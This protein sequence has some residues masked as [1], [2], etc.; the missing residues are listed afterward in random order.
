MKKEEIKNKNIEDLEEGNMNIITKIIV[1]IREYFK[2][3]YSDHVFRKVVSIL[4]VLCFVLNIANLPAYAKSDRRAKDNKEKNEQVMETGKTDTSEVGLVSAEQAMKAGSGEGV[5]TMNAIGNL[6]E[7]QVDSIIEIDEENGIVKDKTKNKVVAV[8]NAETEQVLGYPGQT[9][10]VYYQALV[11]RKKA[12]EKGLVSTA[13]KTGEIEKIGEEAREEIKAEKSAEEIAE[14]KGTVIG[15]YKAEVTKEDEEQEE[16]AIKGIEEENKEN[17]ESSKEYSDVV[18]ELA[19]QSGVS[20]EEVKEGLEEALA[21]KSEEEKEGIIGLLAKFFEQ[22]GDIINCAVNALGEMLNIASKGVLGLQALLVEISTGLF[23]KGN[24]DL[25]N[26]GESQLMTS[27]ETMRAILAEY[28]KEAI[29]V[30]S[31]IEVFMEGLKAGESAVVW[32]NGDHYITVSKLESGNFT[33]VDPNVNNGEAVEY[34]AQGLKDVLT[35]K[36]G[37]DVNG[38]EVGISYQAEGEDGLIRVLSDSEG[39]KEQVKEG[40]VKELSKEEMIEIEGARTI[41]HVEKHIERTVEHHKEKHVEHHSETHTETYTDEQG[42][43]QTNTWTEEWD[44]IW[45]E[46]WDEVK[47]EEVTEEWDEE[48]PDEDAEKLD[49]DEN[50]TLNTQGKD[51]NIEINIEEEIREKDVVDGVVQ[52]EQE[53]ER[54]EIS[55]EVWVDGELQEEGWKRTAG[56]GREITN[57]EEVS[58]TKKNLTVSERTVENNKVTVDSVVVNGKELDKK[59]LKKVNDALAAGGIGT[60]KVADIVQGATQSV[61]I[62]ILKNA[63]NESQ[64]L[65]DAAGAVLSVGEVEVNGVTINRSEGTMSFTDGNGNKVT[66]EFNSMSDKQYEQ[67]LSHVANNGGQAGLNYMKTQRNADKETVFKSAIGKDDQGRTYQEEAAPRSGGNSSVGATI[68][69]YYT[70][71]TMTNVDH[72][73]LQLETYNNDMNVTQQQRFNITEEAGVDNTVMG[74]NDGSYVYVP[75]G[76]VD[77]SRASITTTQYNKDGTKT[78]YDMSIDDDGTMHLTK[79]DYD[80]DGGKNITKIDATEDQLMDKQKKSGSGSGGKGGSDVLGEFAQQFNQVKNGSQGVANLAVDKEDGQRENIKRSDSIYKGYDNIKKIDLSKASVYTETADG[81]KSYQYSK[82]DVRITINDPGSLSLGKD[83]QVNVS[84]GAKGIAEQKIDGVTYRAG[85]T[86]NGDNLQVME[87]TQQ[88]TKTVDGVTVTTKVGIEFDGKNFSGADFASKPEQNV[89]TLKDGTQITGVTIDKDKN[90]KETLKYNTGAKVE[91]YDNDG[92]KYSA[93]LEGEGKVSD[94]KKGVDENSVRKSKEF[95]IELENGEK[96]TVEVY[97]SNGVTFKNGKFSGGDFS[98]KEQNYIKN[99]LPDGTVEYITGI[100][101]EEGENG[102]VGKVVD[103]SE[104]EVKTYDETYIYGKIAEQTGKTEDEVRAEFEAWGA[105]DSETFAESM[106]VLQS[107]LENGGQVVNCATEAIGNVLGDSVDLGWTAIQTLAIDIAAGAFLSNNNEDSDMINTSMYAVKTVLNINSGTGEG[108]EGVIG[109]EDNYKGFSFDNV[110]SLFS[111][112][113][114]GE[115]V[116][117]NIEIEGD[118]GEKIGHYITVTKL[119]NGNYSVE[120]PNIRKGNAVEYTEEGLRNVFNGQEGID[121]KGNET[122]AKYFTNGNG[123]INVVSANLPLSG[124]NKLEDGEMQQIGGAGLLGNILGGI[125]KIFTAATT[126]RTTSRPSYSRPRTTYRPTVRSTP[127]YATR[128]VQ[129]AASVVKP[130]ATRQ[131]SGGGVTRHTDTG[132]GGIGGVLGGLLNL[133]GGR[134]NNTGGSNNSGSSVP[135]ARNN[136]G[137]SF[138]DNIVNKFNSFRDRYTVSHAASNIDGARVTRNGDEW[139]LSIGNQSYSASEIRSSKDFIGGYNTTAAVANSQTGIPGATQSYDRENHEWTVTMPESAGGE[140]YTAEEIGNAKDF[141]NGYKSSSAVTDQETGIPGA[142]RSYDRKNHEWTVTMPE[143]AGG[144]TYTMSEVGDVTDFIN[145]Y[146]SSSAITDQETGIPGATRSFD[147][148][149]HEWVVTMPESAGGESYTMSEIDDAT[150]FINGYNTTSSVVD[151]ETG[152]PGATRSFDRDTHEWVV[153]M[154]ESAG[155]ETY[156]IEEMGDIT[157][158]INGYKTAAAVANSETGIPG[159]TQSYDKEKHE[160]TVIIPSDVAGADPIVVTASDIEKTG[161]KGV[162]DFI[163]QYNKGGDIIK[164]VDEEDGIPDASRVYDSETNTWNIVIPGVRVGDDAIIVPISAIDNVKNFNKQYNKGREIALSTGDQESGVP[165]MGLTYDSERGWLLTYTNNV[166]TDPMYIDVSSIED[167]DSFVADYNTIA[168]AAAQVNDLGENKDDVVI[169]YGDDGWKLTLLGDISVSAEDI[170]NDMDGFI[171]G[172]KTARDV[173]YGLDGYNDESVKVSYDG[174]NG[175][176]VT[177]GGIEIKTDD[178]G[179]GDDAVNKFIQEYKKASDI[180]NSEAGDD[181]AVTY[182]AENNK[183]QI[184]YN[185]GEDKTIRIEDI[186]LSAKDFVAQYQT[187]KTVGIGIDGATYEYDPEKGWKLTVPDIDGE[188][189]AKDI[190]SGDDFV[191]Q[192]KAM[193]SATEGLGENADVAFSFDPAKG[194][195]VTVEGTV[196]NGVDILELGITFGKDEEENLTINLQGYDQ[197][198]NTSDIPDIDEFISDYRDGLEIAQ[199]PGLGLTYDNE[200]HEWILSYNDGEKDQQIKV[201]EIKDKNDFIEQ[202]SKAYTVMTGIDGAKYSYDPEKGWSVTVPEVEDAI[203]ANDIDDA[204]KFVSGY[205]MAKA[206]YEYGNA[207]EENKPAYTYNREDGSWDVT[208]KDISNNITVFNMNGDDITVKSITDENGTEKAEWYIAKVNEAFSI[209]KEEVGDMFS[210]DPTKRIQQIAVSAAQELLTTYGGVVTAVYK[211]FAY[212]L[213][214]IDKEKGGV[215]INEKDGTMTQYGADGSAV[216]INLNYGN[217][218]AEFNYDELRDIAATE[219]FDRALDY[220]KCYG[221]VETITAYDQYGRELYTATNVGYNEGDHCMALEYNFSKFYKGGN[222]VYFQNAEPGSSKLVIENFYPQDPKD[223]SIRASKES[224]MVYDIEPFEEITPGFAGRPMS[225][226]TINGMQIHCGT[227]RSLDNVIEWS[228][229]RDPDT[230]KITQTAKGIDFKN[231]N[232]VPNGQKGDASGFVT[233]TVDGDGTILNINRTDLAYYDSEQTGGSGQGSGGGI[234]GEYQEIL[235]H[236]ERLKA[237]GDFYSGY[238]KI[239]DAWIDLSQVTVRNYDAQNEQFSQ[240]GV[241]LDNKDLVTLVADVSNGGLNDNWMYDIKGAVNPGTGITIFGTGPDGGNYSVEGTTSSVGGEGYDWTDLHSA[242]IGDDVICRINV[243]D[244]EIMTQK[245]CTFSVEN[246][247]GGADYSNPAENFRMLPNHCFVYG[248]ET[249]GF[250]ASYKDA[251]LV[252]QG[253]DTNGKPTTYSVDLSIPNGTAVQADDKFAQ[254]VNSDDILAIRSMKHDVDVYT[255]NGDM[256]YDDDKGFSGADFGSAEDNFIVLPNHAMV[257]GIAVN[258]D[259]DEASYQDSQIV[260]QGFDSEGYDTQYFASLNSGEFY[261]GRT[262]K[263]TDKYEGFVTDAAAMRNINGVEIYT[264]NGITYTDK[265]GF[266]GA[267]YGDPAKNFRLLEN[268]AMVTGIKVDGDTAT[269]ENSQIVQ[270]R[271]D[272]TTYFAY[273]D[274]TFDNGREVKASDK[275]ENHLVDMT[276]KKTFANGEGEDIDVYTRNGITYTDA[277]GFGGAN[278]G[279]PAKNF[280]NFSRGGSNIMVSGIS[281]EGGTV[282]Y[283]DSQMMGSD[284]S[285]N[286]YNV[287]LDSS[288]NGQTV[289]ENF[290][291][292]GYIDATQINGSEDG[293]F[294]RQTGS[295]DDVNGFSGARFVDGNGV[296]YSDFFAQTGNGDF[297]CNI[298]RLGKDNYVAQEN[299]DDPSKSTYL[300]SSQYNAQYSQNQRVAIGISAG[301]RIDKD[302]LDEGYKNLDRAN[303]VRIW[304]TEAQAQEMKDSVHVDT[305]KKSTWHVVYTTNETITTTTW[306]E[307]DY[308]KGEFIDCSSTTTASEDSWLIVT[309]N[310]KVTTTNTIGDK[311]YTTTQNLDWNWGWNGVADTLYDFNE[312]GKFDIDNK[313]LPALGITIDRVSD[314]S[315]INNLVVRRTFSDGDKVHVLQETYRYDGEDK[316]FEGVTNYK[317]N[318]TQVA[319]KTAS[320]SEIEDPIA[321]DFDNNGFLYTATG[322]STEVTLDDN[323]KATGVAMCSENAAIIDGEYA[324]SVVTDGAYKIFGDTPEEDQILNCSNAVIATHNYETKVGEYISGLTDDQLEATKF[325]LMGSDGKNHTFRPYYEDGHLIYNL[326]GYENKNV[327]YYDSS[328]NPNSSLSDEIKKYE[329]QGYTVEVVS[330]TSDEYG[331]SYVLNLK[332]NDVTQMEDL[333]FNK[334]FDGN[335]IEGG[336]DFGI[337]GITFDPTSGFNVSASLILKEK[338][339][340]RVTGRTDVQTGEGGETPESVDETRYKVSAHINGDQLDL[341]ATDGDEARVSITFGLGNLQKD[342]VGSYSFDHFYAGTELTFFKP[343]NLESV[344]NNARDLSNSSVDLGKYTQTINTTVSGGTIFLDTDTKLSDLAGKVA[345]KGVNGGTVHVENTITVEGENGTECVQIKADLADGQNWENAQKT[346]LHGTDLENLEVAKPGDTILG[347]EYKGNGKIDMGGFL[348][349]NG[350]ID[351]NKSVTDVSIEKHG[352]A[353]ACEVVAGVVVSIVGIVEAIFVA[354]ETLAISLATGTSFTDNWNEHFENADVSALK[355]AAALIKDKQYSDV[356]G[357]E[358]ASAIFSGVAAVAA[359]VVAVLGIIASPFTAGASAVGGV[360]FAG[361]VIGAVIGTTVAAVGA[362]KAAF[363]ASE[364]LQMYLKTGD[365]KYMDAFWLNLGLAIFSIATAGMAADFGNIG[366]GLA[367]KLVGKEALYMAAVAA[368]KSGG[369][370]AAEQ[371]VKSYGEA[372]TKAM[373]RHATKAAARRSASLAAKYTAQSLGADVSNIVIKQAANFSLKGAMNTLKTAPGTVLKEGLKNPWVFRGALMTTSSVMDGGISLIEKLTGRNLDGTFLGGLHDLSRVFSAQ[374]MLGFSQ[375]SEDSWLNN[376]VFG[377]EGLKWSSVLWVGGYVFGPG[378]ANGVAGFVSGVR[379]GMAE[380][381][382]FASAFGSQISS[383]FS[384]FRGNISQFGTYTHQGFNETLANVGKLFG[385]SGGGLTGAI[386]AWGSL[387]TNMYRMV[388]LNIGMGLTGSGFRTLGLVGNENSAFGKSSLGSLLNFVLGEMGVSQTGRALTID[389][390]FKNSFANESLANSAMFGVIMYALMPTVSGMAKGIKGVEAIEE[391]AA[392]NGSA[393][394]K[395]FDGTKEFVNSIW[396]EGFNEGIVQGLV[397][398]F[399]GPQA[400]EYISEFAF[401]DTSG[402]M[403]FMQTVQTA[404]GNSYYGAQSAARS[405]TQLYASK[406]YTDITFEAVRNVNGGYSIVMSGLQGV[407]NSILKGKGFAGVSAVY[408]NGSLSFEM[409]NNFSGNRA[410]TLAKA[411]AA[412]ASALNIDLNSLSR[413]SENSDVVEI[414]ERLLGDV[415]TPGSVANRYKVSEVGSYSSKSGLQS[416]MMGAYNAMNMPGFSGNIGSV[417]ATSTDFSK[418]SKVTDITNAIEQGKIAAEGITPSEIS[419]P[420]FIDIF[421]RGDTRTSADLLGVEINAARVRQLYGNTEGNFDVGKF[422]QEVKGKEISEQLE[423][424][425]SVVTLTQAGVNMEDF[426][427]DG[428]LGEILS[429]IIQ[430]DSKNNGA[431]AR[432]QIAQWGAMLA[433]NGLVSGKVLIGIAE[434]CLTVNENG[435]NRSATLSDFN[436]T[437]L[438]QARTV[439]AFLSLMQQAIVKGKGNISGAINDIVEEVINE[440]KKA[441]DIEIELQGQ[442]ELTDQ[443]KIILREME[444]NSSDGII[445]DY[446]G[447]RLQGINQDIITTNKDKFKVVDK[448]SNSGYEMVNKKGNYEI[449]VDGESYG[450]F[451]I[452]ALFEMGVLSEFNSTDADALR[453]VSQ[454][455]IDNSRGLEYEILDSNGEKR[456]ISV[457][458][459]DSV[460]MYRGLVNRFAQMAKGQIKE[461]NNQ[462]SEEKINELA[463]EL[464]KKQVEQILQSEDLREL[465]GNINRGDSSQ[466]SD[467]TTINGITLDKIAD[468][469]GFGGDNVGLVMRLYALSQYSSTGE[470]EHA[471]DIE[472]DNA[473]WYEEHKKPGKDG[474]L[475]KGDLTKFRDYVDSQY[476]SE[477]DKLLAVRLFA[478]Q[479]LME[480][481]IYGGNGLRASQMELLSALLGNENAALDMGGG[482]TISLVVDSV[483]DRILMGDNANFEILVGNGAIQNY[484]GTSMQDFLQFVGM[485]MVAITDFKTSEGTKAQELLDAY[486]DPNK[487][488]IMDP[489]TR[490]HLKNDAANGGQ[491][492]ELIN[493]ALNSVRR[494]V[495]DEIHLWALT[496][497]ASVISNGSYETSE[498]NIKSARNMYDKLNVSQMLSHLTEIN[499]YEQGIEIESPLGD[500][501]VSRFRSF[502]DWIEY[503]NQHSDESIMA[504]IGESS[505][506]VQVVF[507]GDIETKVNSDSSINNG[508]VLSF[509]R[510]LFTASDMGGAAFGNDGTV[511]PVS[512]KVEN[513]MVISDIF[514][515]MGYA[516]NAWALQ[517]EQ[518]GK[519]NNLEE[520]IKAATRESDTSMQTSL[521][522]IYDGADQMLALVGVSGT[523]L[524]LEQL[525]INRTGSGK[526]YMVSGG[527]ANIQGQEMIQ[528]DSTS[529][530]YRQE[531]ISDIQ[532]GIADTVTDSLKAGH[533]DI[534]MLAKTAPSISIFMEA[535]Q[536]LDA[537]TLAE[538]EKQ[539]FVVFD[540]TT[541]TKYEIKDGRL[542]ESSYKKEHEYYN[543]KGEK[544]TKRTDEANR[545]QTAKDKTIRKIIIDNDAG[546]TGTDYQGDYSLFVL[547]SHM[548]SNT[549]LAQLLQRIGRPNP[550]GTGR[551]EATRYILQ[552][553]SAVKSKLGE[554]LVNEEFINFFTSAS[555]S[556]T[557]L[558]NARASELFSEIVQQNADGS[559]EIKPEILSQINDQKIQKDI[560]ELTT[561][562]TEVSNINASIR[563]AVSDAVRDRMI[564]KPLRTMLANAQTAEEKAVVRKALDEVL[565]KGG[566]DANANLTGRE[567]AQDMYSDN[568][569]E[570]I[571]RTIAST[572]QQAQDLFKTLREQLSTDSQAYS[573]IDQHLSEINSMDMSAVEQIG[574]ENIEKIANGE[575]ISSLSQAE[576]LDEFMGVI[577]TFERYIA[578]TLAGKMMDV[579]TV[580]TNEAVQQE[581]GMENGQVNMNSEE[582][583]SAKEKGLVVERDGKVYLTQLGQNYAQLAQNRA[584]ITSENMSKV[585]ALILQMLLGGGA[586]VPPEEEEFVASI[587]KDLAADKDIKLPSEDETRLMLDIARLLEGNNVTNINGLNNI[588][589]MLSEDAK[590][591]DIIKES[592]LGIR[593]MEAIINTSHPQG[594]D[595]QTLARMMLGGKASA[596]EVAAKANEIYLPT[597]QSMALRRF[598]QG[599]TGEADAL[600]QSYDSLVNNFYNYSSQRYALTPQEQAQI[601]IQNRQEKQ[602][603]F[604]QNHPNLS[605]VADILKNL[606]LAP[607]GI[608]AS[609]PRFAIMGMVGN[610][611]PFGNE[612]TSSIFA[613]GFNSFLGVSTSDILLNKSNKSNAQQLSV[614][615]LALSLVYGIGTARDRISDK[616]ELEKAVEDIS[617]VVNPA[618]SDVA[619]KSAEEIKTAMAQAGMTITE[620]TD[621]AIDNLKWLQ[622]NRPKSLKNMTLSALQYPKS[623]EKLTNVEVENTEEVLKDNIVDITERVNEARKAQDVEYTPDQVQGMLLENCAVQAMKEITRTVPTLR[624]VDGLTKIAVEMVSGE[625]EYEGLDGLKAAGKEETASIGIIKDIMNYEYALVADKGAI[626]SPV[627][628]YFDKNHVAQVSSKA[629]I[630]KIEAQGY[631]FTGIVLADKKVI[632]GNKGMGEEIMLNRVYGVMKG[633]EVPDIIKYLLAVYKEGNRADAMLSYIGATGISKD[634]INEA[635]LNK[636]EHAVQIGAE[637]KVPKLIVDAQVKA[638]T[639]IREVLFATLDEGKEWLDKANETEI[640]K[641]IEANKR[642]S[643]SV[644]TKSVSGGKVN[645]DFVINIV[646]LQKAIADKDLSGKLAQMQELMKTGKTDLGALMEMN[647]EKE[648]KMPMDLFKIS[649]IYAVASAA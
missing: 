233:V 410:E 150:D 88:A 495:T 180:K 272:G 26:A 61:A 471:Q 634:E 399:V 227:I 597:A 33:I 596:K 638:L 480:S 469:V 577:M 593:D 224:A 60:G 159:A 109:N 494:V 359:V 632:A 330:S 616:K 509:V 583:K 389:E 309:T 562:M 490:G 342:S 341:K 569:S 84:A 647:G 217:R 279:D 198:I 69:T 238:K 75:G 270:E 605:N 98:D 90:G 44:E 328:Y 299:K 524:G 352:F 259:T 168:A 376:N 556:E 631:T 565:R 9:D 223:P 540:R 194:L 24:A 374:G 514:F 340:F 305:D 151:Q 241:A 640:V 386:Q 174:S 281:V 240:Q 153:T 195:Q 360:V 134:N 555:N 94:W 232:G 476:T 325:T 329:E 456:T 535:I 296:G 283:K 356:T 271:D 463:E 510:G 121:A 322:H 372:Y 343:S 351:F 465:A 56:E 348:N 530:G 263:S 80:K 370:A 137:G 580:V 560:L 570:Y 122:G 191:T 35:G 141:V 503:R 646:K 251:Q 262:V 407:A 104:A 203:S 274:D 454:E 317:T 132:T 637:G 395:M 119:E 518:T 102:S 357:G 12:F 245:G 82:G 49:L 586:P 264:Q 548:Y 209:A 316:D 170:R 167:I 176:V 231:G 595:R 290:E 312:L 304:P 482:K 91:Q 520:F 1:G 323:G 625:S 420:G 347:G 81:A 388:A 77:E 242:D 478:N 40:T 365:E 71:D 561:F 380:G 320:Y 154:P 162:Q 447:S 421:W 527:R 254:Y 484:V 604:E 291:Y 62:D 201:S 308:E 521:A 415:S 129:R 273:L 236:T 567:S 402:S 608:L 620:D 149:T 576:T 161:T 278:Y 451:G 416:I 173:K 97:T 369:K 41:H 265:D 260:Y 485:D 460:A 441:I 393:F 298:K 424:L 611:L 243:N 602:F 643:Q 578:P 70:D 438:E 27:F 381:Q 85:V 585:L 139:S 448:E 324:G 383:M 79:T 297:I 566:Y 481:D 452:T 303:V 20:E 563:F 349:W 430:S 592:N 192:Y 196:F 14:A 327:T 135:S 610:L 301:T 345:E 302:Y 183:W 403:S 353:R 89:A 222:S 532:K 639:G 531:L 591:F 136:S 178:I 15:E 112:T 635:V 459:S 21:G 541:D 446:L 103:Y 618:L 449:F 499:N 606:V 528:F 627:I 574:R 472:E 445:S 258:D 277:G 186:N 443:R 539:G 641:K 493:E 95:E 253:E 36:A 418:E 437:T 492:G 306:K 172:Y 314:G 221:A 284:G 193:K 126:R 431:D 600:V 206:M 544:E 467:K 319:I 414:G 545:D 23:E 17:I 156:T 148:D 76:R 599:R 584:N 366:A 579:S 105:T 501:T 354:I 220:A 214:G 255:Q 38:K 422:K 409:A 497:T 51:V 642:V 488:I 466:I 211:N 106:T 111:N 5:S 158:F 175:W 212:G 626:T 52:E 401:P 22:G 177:V 42:N 199:Q 188:I 517:S 411:R 68:K 138:F 615:E 218:S 607:V 335:E 207:D 573:Q 11:N 66:A 412:V 440:N 442:T 213:M 115:S 363:D 143:S 252:G 483:V 396:E 155:G 398:P 453:I 475:Y 292:R 285:G 624:L 542:V 439:G 491:T 553:V 525:I 464:A 547:D 427:A 208:V 72:K 614:P 55:R 113:K 468:F 282:T 382:T 581:F 275:Y 537:G 25:I 190:K 3:T 216:V 428:Q 559:F 554:Y 648:L 350:T 100:A 295:Y 37:V 477:A 157:N 31:D 336:W 315:G 589:N 50:N 512:T 4:V 645:T 587:S 108:E 568:G 506:D 505:A 215:V 594:M 276:A 425:T 461:Q 99:E 78:Q 127:S 266:G 160:W 18:S 234:A 294:W 612:Q 432:M 534:L 588:I 622:E 261:N 124:G 426:I 511:K 146:N 59:F 633:E 179:A 92:A 533:T 621:A 408:A 378:I 93:V 53:I 344:N 355:L 10:I 603:E 435:I 516:A 45:Y 571:Q 326:V 29:G 502:N 543:G 310:N 120:D 394:S 228:T 145:G 16:S 417:L 86:V 367:A 377:I 526:V 247:F 73:E 379:A 371:V 249:D 434:S 387:G 257:N 288:I 48:V 513:D 67:M 549:D 551:G 457:S 338:D 219:G 630:D 368:A 609:V 8:Y 229:T 205:N 246:G 508:E 332:K 462:L 550:Q 601:F 613:K 64:T 346:V 598:V 644:I 116:I 107:M 433:S 187:S 575:D 390:V 385:G 32:V 450:T 280:I 87:G 489:T 507:N 500:F 334:G 473:E 185:D 572:A 239:D 629:D 364:S 125:K 256:T 413:A 189:L 405:M 225:D 250:T 479:M 455:T 375:I 321:A 34:S 458:V 331:T 406:G 47:E 423:Q 404:N 289:S 63:K 536:T 147:R 130:S 184:T 133:F 623:L 373:A 515:Q 46:E 58:S 164:G 436:V 30:A 248:I 619:T 200:T 333:T 101:V 444:N 293:T 117:V 337:D 144:E 7:E 204:D 649:D 43:T 74:L 523:V 470:L 57:I 487:V 226:Y 307:W 538:L 529:S 496:R 169:S 54:E 557:Y 617:G 13:K 522:A 237:N 123:K 384:T 131:Y 429:S 140:R 118:G 287:P 39:I 65:K 582:F 552:D 358:A 397:T 419:G 361:F 83:G 311:T 163:D 202:Y 110:E 165:G 267:N 96:R 152:I 182:D 244:V 114:V 564:I 313:Y 171:E 300:M 546:A 235:K 486:N 197:P 6:S 2:E 268:E 474:G 19:K 142:T 391:S 286:S 210:G 339:I 628:A 128:S 504:V 181:F 400:A 519:Y 558:K 498:A 269:Y 318:T 230:G 166:S 362:A 636:I 28:G 392:S 590:I